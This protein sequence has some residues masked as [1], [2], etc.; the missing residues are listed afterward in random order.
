MGVSPNHPKLYYF[1]IVLGIPYFKK[2]PYIP[3]IGNENKQE[4]QLCIAIC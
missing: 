4:E 3:Y 2:P 1:T